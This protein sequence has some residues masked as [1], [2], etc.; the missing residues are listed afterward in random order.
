M[1]GW[2]ATWA[3]SDTSKAHP[4]GQGRE[5]T[6]PPAILSARHLAA[7]TPWRQ[8]SFWDARPGPEDT[9]HPYLHSRRPHPLSHARAGTWGEE[10]VRPARGLGPWAAGDWLAE[11]RTEGVWLARVEGG[12]R[13]STITRSR[14]LIGWAQA[15]GGGV[16]APEPSSG[17]WA[18]G[19][20]REFLPGNCLLLFQLG[21]K[22]S[23]QFGS[24]RGSCRHQTW[25]GPNLSRWSSAWRSICHSQTCGRSNASSMAR[26]PGVG[27]RSWG[28]GTW[29]QGVWI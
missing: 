28:G 12:A 22:G 5:D 16:S 11:A 17:F 29:G 1:V 13:V 2:G 21:A 6:H 7:S 26:R 19:E 8:V 9:A 25:R 3:L 15:R 18:R 24:G 20:G 4:S 23:R 27:H 10:S 14:V